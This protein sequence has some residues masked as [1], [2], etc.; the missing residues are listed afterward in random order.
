M[1]IPLFNIGGLASGLDTSSMI[2]ELVKLERLPI[3]R[4]Q[5]R[6]SELTKVDNAW[7][8]VNTKLSALRSAV[9]KLRK[10]EAFDGFV[11][12]TSSD[13]TA[14]GVTV[15]GAAAP[16]GLSFTITQLAKAHQFAFAELDAPSASL[17]SGAAETLSITKGGT[18]YDLTTTASTTLQSLAADINKLDAG[19]SAQVVQTTP[20]KHRLVVSSSETGTANAAT[21]TSAPAALGSKTDLQ[22][23]S[24]AVLDLGGG[25]TVSR[26]SNTITD[27]VNGVT[28][29]LKRAGA[30]VTITTS[31]DKDA[32]TKAVKEMVDALNGVLTTVKDLTKYNPETKV[33]GVLQGNGT[34]RQLANDLRAEVSATIADLTGSYTTAS[35]VGISLTRDGLVT[36]DETKLR[37]ALDTNFTAVA[38]LFNHR[39]GSTTDGAVGYTSSTS[40]TVAG[41]YGVEITAPATVAAATGAAFVAGAARTLTVTAGGVDVSV[42]LLDGDDAATVVGKINAALGT[43]DVATMSAD[44]DGGALRLRDSRYG[45]AV[46][47]SVAGSGDWGLDGT[48][49]GTDVEGTI[50]GDD[51]VGSGQ[52]LQSST[53][54]SAGLALTVSATTP[55]AYGSVTV[56]GGLSGALDRALRWAEGDKTSSDPQQAAGAIQRARNTLK[57]EIRRYDDQ[58]AAFEVR[59]ESR[60][61]TLRKKF[62]AMESALASAQSQTSFLGML[63]A[64]PRQ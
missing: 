52:V 19:L 18:T 11:S 63:P 45:S 23:A 53:G 33:A 62:A 16:G 32:A 41:T 47:F 42:S 36:L 13:D 24:D 51:A 34:A 25:M 7:G 55:G 46:S 64:Q 56:A 39:S 60:E 38:D 1:A 9:D 59:V 3:T 44:V 50:G 12:S 43:A 40:R 28:V 10:P 22:A 14:A 15:T 5:A 4:F 58:I 54:Q 29:Q 49:T 35:S 6:Q 37:T 8:T 2:S 26:S 57:S 17:W 27:L 31:R 21:I 48:F 30:P 20:G 61:L